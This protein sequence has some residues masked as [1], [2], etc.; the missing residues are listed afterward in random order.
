MKNKEK[1]YLYLQNQGRGKLERISYEPKLRTALADCLYERYKVPK[2]ISY[3]FIN[4]R[5]RF[6]EQA[7]IS[8][9]ML[10][11]ILDSINQSVASHLN[12]QD[13]F[14][15]D[16][17]NEYSKYQY[18]AKE[19]ISFPL[20]L[21]CMEIVPGKQWIGALPLSVLMAFRDKQIVNYN[22][23][24][25]RPMTRIQ[26][27]TE[28]SYRITLNNK[29]VQ[30]IKELMH[31]GQY[32]ADTI[33]FNI[34]ETSEADWYYDGNK[35]EL[36]FNSLDKL[37]IIDG[38]HRYIAI[39]QE[40]I[41]N[42]NFDLTME[43]RFVNF[44]EEEA[45]QFIWQSDQKTHMK[46]SVITSYAMARDSNIIAQRINNSPSFLLQGEVDENEGK[47]SMSDF[48]NCIGYYY[49]SASKKLTNQ[50]RL[51]V[52]NE[53]I[54]RFNLVLNFYPELVERKS[55]IH[56]GELAIIFW[57][58]N[59]FDLTDKSEWEQCKATLKQKLPKM[60]QIRPA[61]LGRRV[62]SKALNRDIEAL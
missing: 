15:E 23:R 16:E 14:S 31:S 11:F 10:F 58:M 24:T 51:Q 35:K 56:F 57:A 32:I 9:V 3:D 53:I 7:D 62:I 33:T 2:D 52:Q 49:T 39:I 30:S 59:K 29:A 25:Q 22:P 48:C 26:R 44:S 1:A 18:E 54:E 4:G 47:I 41:E 17:I 19:K 40:T 38:F 13:Y 42:P 45:K 36:V 61:L 21:P 27:G 50:E 37:D 43:V 28:T 5:I 8:D 6:T 20:S 12:L 46:K 60:K 34:P 55:K